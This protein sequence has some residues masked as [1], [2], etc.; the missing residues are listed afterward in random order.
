MATVEELLRLRGEVTAK[1]AKVKEL[2]DTLAQLREELARLK[3]EA[4]PTYTCPHCGVVFSSLAELN[5]HIASVHPTEPPVVAVPEKPWYRRWQTYLV[6]GIGAVIT[7]I[8]IGTKKKK[9]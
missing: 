3:G 9:K 2:E 1:I 8:A 4:P 5:D 6:L 7:G